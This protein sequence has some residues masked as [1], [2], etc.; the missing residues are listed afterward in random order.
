MTLF[1][2]IIQSLMSTTNPVSWVSNM[3]NAQSIATSEQKS[4]LMVFAGSDW[5]APCIKFKKNILVTD[6]FQEYEKNNLVILYLDFPAKKKNKLSKEQTKHN[7]ML[8]DQY[9]RSGRFPHIILLDKDGESI[10]TMAYDGQPPRS[11]IKEIEE[12]L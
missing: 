9:N 12:A 5:C 8:A 6:E 2:I 10:K 1:L 7:E 4:I 11:F 3:A